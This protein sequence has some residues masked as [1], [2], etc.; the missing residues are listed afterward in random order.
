MRRMVFDTGPF[1]LL[2]TREEGS[3]KAREAVLRHERG[4]VEIYMHPNNLAEAY[5]VISLIRSE[6]PELLERDVSPEVVVRSAYATLNVVSDEET[7]VKLGSLKLKYPEKPWGDLS[8]AAL[9]LR[10]ADGGPAPVVVL[11][12]E[13][14]L[15]DVAEVEVVRVSEL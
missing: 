14:H 4:E 12:G 9:S 7:T 8:A 13:R 6:R 5:R 10:L 1:L 15:D 2:F 11:D 3:E